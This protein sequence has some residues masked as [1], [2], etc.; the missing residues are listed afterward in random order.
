[1]LNDYQLILCSMT[2]NSLILFITLISFT[3]CKNNNIEIIG[4][5]TNPI[6]G[7]Y[8]YLDELRSGTLV[9]VDSVPMPEDGSFVFSVGIESPAFYLLKTDE[10]NFLTML[11]EP[12]ERVEIKSD[13]DSLNFPASI[14]GSKGTELMVG[15]SIKLRETVNKLSGLR[16]IY[17]K[18]V[19]T[20]GLPMVMD[21]LDSI[22]TTYMED[23]NSF[24]KKYID[25][26]LTSLVSLTA[27]YQQVAPG[28]Y[29]LNP[30]RDLDYFIKVDSSLFSLYPDYEPVRTLHEQVR[31]LVSNIK[32]Q[33]IISTEF[34]YG[35]VAPE[36]ALPDTKGDTIKLSSTKGNVVLLDFWAAWCR[37]CRIENPNL[38]KAYDL[39]HE[40]GF[41]IYQ[42]SLDRTKD[43]W[44][45][46]IR[47]DNLGRWIHVSDLKYWKS[48]VIPIYNI[49]Q[50]PANF[51]IDKEGRIIASDLRGEELLNKLSQIFN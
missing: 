35:T 12:G 6:K 40:K 1:M 37:P 7:E 25:D 24:T 20:P 44:I 38:V 46:G 9:T 11:L 17:L 30:Q 18:N 45:T 50:I 22:A 32:A 51:L 39:Y 48:S 29:V 47:E 8:I 34:R 5:L 4:K 16:E 14:T 42:V 2:R 19:G 28:E 21:R 3:G 13:F 27:L 31:N 33:N 43:A 41:T 23:I 10:N 26:N 15:Y 49:E 36:I